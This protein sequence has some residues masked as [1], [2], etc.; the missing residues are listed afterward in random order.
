MLHAC[1]TSDRLLRT[2]ISDAWVTVPRAKSAMGLSRSVS[3]MEH[4]LFGKPVSTFPHHALD[5][6]WSMI[7]SQNRYPLFRIMLWIFDGV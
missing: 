7:S 1:V 6:C 4:D 5:L 2:S 3:L